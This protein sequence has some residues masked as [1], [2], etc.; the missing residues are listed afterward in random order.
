MS[1]VDTFESLSVADIE[2]FV[3]SKQEETLH[4]EFKAITRPD[5]SVRDDKRNLAA[6]LSGFANS[7]GGLI[8]WGVDARKNDD[9]IDCAVALKEI[10]GVAAF[11][12]RLN[13]LTGEA[14]LPRID[15]VRHRPIARPNGN[16][17]AAT[18]VPESDA[19][20][21]MAKLG[22]DRYFKR[23]GTSFYRMEHFDVADMFGRRRRPKLSVTTQIVG[24]ADGARI[25]LGLRND[26]R[27]SA[28][29]PYLAF[30]VPF[31]FKRD[32]FGLDGNRN[33]GMRRLLSGG[34]DLPF[35]YG[36]D[37][38]FV[39]HPGIVH[40]VASISLGFSPRG[41]PSSDVHINYAICAEDVPLEVGTVVVPVYKLL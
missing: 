19:G 20:P 36:E 21:H 39:I 17:F 29:A 2:Q 23:S 18:L 6:A 8:V 13:E 40:E 4:L 26:G 41:V 22:E 16:G 10:T 7:D 15:G 12:S 1:L 5:L 25:V 28:R 34:Q 30:D 31:P 9:G 33:E 27:S 3:Q 11:T 24:I 32:E 35:R 38:N 37:T 14:V